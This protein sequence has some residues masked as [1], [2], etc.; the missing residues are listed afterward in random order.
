MHREP[1][2]EDLRRFILTSVPSVP[3][4]EALLIYRDAHGAAVETDA[5]ARRLY[6]SAKAAIEIATQ[7][8]EAGVVST[9]DAP[10]PAYRF[11]PQTRELAGILDVLADYYRSHLVEVS[12]LIHSRTAR[13]AQQ[14]ADAFKLRK[15]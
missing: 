14:F 12:D 2:P 4:V 8:L 11:A 9:A 13:K 15:D 1:I 3:Y 6:V 5:L 7:L 10:S